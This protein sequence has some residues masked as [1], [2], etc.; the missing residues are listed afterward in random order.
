MLTGNRSQPIYE[1]TSR[2]LL[3]TS[4]P[5]GNETEETIP[6]R[7]GRWRAHHY[8][9]GPPRWLHSHRRHECCDT[10]HLKFQKPQWQHQRMFR[11]RCTATTSCNMM[12]NTHSGWILRD[13]STPFSQVLRAKMWG[14]PSKLFPS[15]S[16]KA[17]SAGSSEHIRP[18]AAS[19]Q[20]LIGLCTLW[21]KLDPYNSVQNYS[22]INLLFFSCK[23]HCWC[24]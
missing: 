5:A 12:Q 10:S 16:K 22:S 4:S 17:W 2:A 7:D 14:T 13:F 9:C 21:L 18:T 20:S 6:R 11:S 24:I 3:I 23:W 1:H 15:G 19:R 8:C